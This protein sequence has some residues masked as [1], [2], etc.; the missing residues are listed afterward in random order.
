MKRTM[1]F[2]SQCF[3]GSYDVNLTVSLQPTNSKKKTKVCQSNL[4]HM[5]WSSVQQLVH[6]SVTGCPMRAGDLLASGTISG[7]EQHNFGSMLELSWKGSREVI[8]DGAEG[9]KEVRKFLNDGDAVIMEGWCRKEGIGRVGFGQCSAR[10]LPAV[11]FPYEPED[12]I[13]KVATPTQPTPQFTNFKL[14]GFWRSSCTWRVRI[15]LAAKGIPHEIIPIDLFS[16]EQMID[17]YTTKNYMQQVPTLE[18]MDE[19]NTI[20]R[21][22]QSLAIIEFLD[23]AFADRGGRMLPLEPIARAK[24]KEIAEI[25]NSGIQPLQ[26]LS[27][28]EMLDNKAVPPS[29]PGEAVGKKIAKE[30]IEKGL[31]TLENNVSHLHAA[32]RKAGPFAVGSFGPT[33]ADICL[34][35]QLYNGQRFGIEVERIC[36][37]LVEIEKACKNH[38]WFQAVLP[39]MQRS[40]VFKN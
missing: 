20:V 28:I 17:D 22:T 38:P 8:L 30:V 16:K 37:T 40:T 24:V 9:S 29:N 23:S 5:Y 12:K 19:N 1:L 7:K 14:Y 31:V 34:V 6:H 18:F 21:L 11:P 4:K 27:I 35:P 25:V 32:D 36:P 2:P 13:G 33:I 15:A 39:D 3:K 26:N 10:I